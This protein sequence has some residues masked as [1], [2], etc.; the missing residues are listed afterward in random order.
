[1]PVKFRIVP[2]RACAYIPFVSRDSQTSQRG[3]DED[4]QKAIVADQLPHPVPGRAIRTDGRAD[5]RAAVPHD[6]R[7]HE[8]DAEDVRVAVFFREPAADAGPNGPPPSPR[9]SLRSRSPPAHSSSTSRSTTSGG[10]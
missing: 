10:C 4:F 6:L 3:V 2:A 7:G 1:M 8:A 9:L 5:D